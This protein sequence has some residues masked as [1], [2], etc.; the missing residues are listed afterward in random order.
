MIRSP[1]DM[2]EADSTSMAPAST[3]SIQIQSP[4][5]QTPAGAQYRPL[6]VQ[7]GVRSTIML[8]RYCQRIAP[9]WQPEAVKWARPFSFRP[10]SRIWIAHEESWLGLSCSCSCSSCVLSW[11]RILPTYLPTLLLAT[12]GPDD[13]SCTPVQHQDNPSL[14]ANLCFIVQ[15]LEV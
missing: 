12:L 3:P 7:Y 13:G 1:V 15:S 5:P 6:I 4:A 9:Q 14:E 11:P 2:L 8:Y 10:S